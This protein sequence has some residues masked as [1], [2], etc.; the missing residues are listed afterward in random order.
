MSNE[1]AILEL[2]RRWKWDLRQF[3]LGIP[4]KCKGVL[5][6]SSSRLALLWIR[7]GTGGG[8]EQSRGVPESGSEVHAT[9]AEPRCTEGRPA[10]PCHAYESE[11]WC[12]EGLKTPPDRTCRASTSMTLASQTDQTESSTGQRAPHHWGLRTATL[13]P[14][15]SAPGRPKGVVSYAD[16]AA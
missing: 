3:N 16:Q 11:S 9:R 12:N 8:A 14:L 1:R 10:P 15:S 6:A 13:P 2:L 7:P 5:R 4:A